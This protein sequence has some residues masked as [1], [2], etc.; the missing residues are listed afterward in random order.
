M[1]TRRHTARYGWVS[2]ALI[3]ADVVAISQY[4]GQ[5]EAL[6]LAI[7]TAAAFW[8]AAEAGKRMRYIP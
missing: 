1:N 3:A 8:L 7:P 4:R 6:M 5:W 2:L